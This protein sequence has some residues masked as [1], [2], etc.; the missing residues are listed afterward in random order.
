MRIQVAQSGNVW[1]F[2]LSGRLER[3][4]PVDELRSAM[5]TAAGRGAQHVVLD[6]STVSMVD[7]S[8][9][10]L[11]VRQLTSL[12]QRGGSI[13]IVNPSRAAQQTL[14]IV[15]LLHLFPSFTSVDEAVQSFSAAG[16]AT[17]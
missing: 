17:T 14:K 5:E 15:G 6:L 13:K 1:V 12:K 11:L 8:G 10:G 3:G 9:I 2:T 7:S 4:E 16:A